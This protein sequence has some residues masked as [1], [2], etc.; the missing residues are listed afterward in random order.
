MKTKTTIYLI[1]MSLLSISIINCKESNNMKTIN[2]DFGKKYAEAWSGQNAEA[3]AKFFATNGSLKVNDETL[4]VGRDAIANVA[5][6]FMSTFP[7]MIV[8]LDSFPITPNGAEFLWTLTGTNSEPNGTG[9]KVNVSG[10]ERLKF[11]KDGLTTESIGSFDEA[12]Y[13]RQ[14]KFGVQK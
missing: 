1:F 5:Q 13:N 2:K 4:A 9:N 11:D 12:E 8:A 6:S 14:L 10:V 3:Y 7:D